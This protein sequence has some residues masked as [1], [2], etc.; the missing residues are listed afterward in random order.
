MERS[1]ETRVDIGAEILND[2]TEGGFV[3]VEAASG[4]FLVKVLVMV[5]NEH[6]GE[7][8][9]EIAS[10]DL[11]AYAVESLVGALEHSRNVSTRS[12]RVYSSE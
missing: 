7:N 8:A 4:S 9:I 6:T 5:K 3:R 1:V 11:D 2:H 12:G 10:V